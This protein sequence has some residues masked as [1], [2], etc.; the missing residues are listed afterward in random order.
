M[1]LAGDVGQLPKHQ[2]R[3]RQISVS[4]PRKQMR[5]HRF[6]ATGTCAIHVHPQATSSLATAPLR[7]HGD[8]KAERTA[9]VPVPQLPLHRCFSAE[10]RSEHNKPLALCRQGLGPD[11]YVS[12]TARVRLEC[13]EVRSRCVLDTGLALVDL[14]PGV[15]L[16][17]ASAKAP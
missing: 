1:I 4:G 17:R 7:R 5:R 14:D 13:C 3:P 8:G 9:A 16:K 12:G 6:L 15:V 11:L 2:H 10:R